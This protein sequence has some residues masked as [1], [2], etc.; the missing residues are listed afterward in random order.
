MRS[1]PYS[2]MLLGQDASIDGHGMTNHETG[3]R[4]AKPY[5][6]RCNFFRFA[7]A[8]DWLP[9]QHRLYDL[10]IAILR[11]REAIGVL[12]I[13]GQTALIRIPCVA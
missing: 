1:L 8:S 13:P 9:R 5:D 4:G 11:N 7:E 3:G 10:L 12:M 6:G 2:Q